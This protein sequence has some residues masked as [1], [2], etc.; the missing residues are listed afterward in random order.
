[1]RLAEGM[2]VESTAYLDT[3]LVRR[4]LEG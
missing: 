4:A 2:I 1:M 3:D